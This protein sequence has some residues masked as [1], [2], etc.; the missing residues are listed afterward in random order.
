VI[1]GIVTPTG[2]PVIRLEAGGQTWDAIV[3]TG[4]NSDLELPSEL[5]PLLT[6]TFIGQM[7]F[8][9]AGGRTIVED[10]YRVNF[11]VRD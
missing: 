3:D 9:L 4:F 5:Q 11:T 8:I 6:A 7:V 10:V 2:V 1:S